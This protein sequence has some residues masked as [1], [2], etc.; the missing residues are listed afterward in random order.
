MRVLTVMLLALLLV[1]C[2]E[3]A[4]VTPPPD[5]PEPT[6]M[7]EG[8]LSGDAQLEGGCAWLETDD[9]RYEVLYPTGY[10]VAFDPLRLLGPDGET[11]AEEGE[12]V[13]VRGTEASDMV[14]AC[15]VGTLFQASEVLAGN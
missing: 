15:Q 9:G 4:A 7:L 13:T 12:A 1:A 5:E 11:V 8:T 3:D 10:E 6:G 14:S 2:G